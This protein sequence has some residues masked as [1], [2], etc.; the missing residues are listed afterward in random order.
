MHSILQTLCTIIPTNCIGME[1]HVQLATETKIFCGNKEDEQ[2]A[3]RCQI[4][5]DHA[6]ENKL[7]PTN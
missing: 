4:I 2:R 5:H 3:P 6:V 7:Q 1:I